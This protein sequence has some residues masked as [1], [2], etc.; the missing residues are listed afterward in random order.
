MTTSAAR[1]SILAMLTTKWKAGPKFE[2]AE[3]TRMVEEGLV[4]RDYFNDVPRYCLPHD[5]SDMV[6]PDDHTN[7]K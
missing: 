4:W 7:K 3:L 1:R 5:V 6:I 2:D